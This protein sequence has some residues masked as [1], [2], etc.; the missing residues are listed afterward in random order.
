MLP[1]YKNMLASYEIAGIKVIDH[2]KDN[3]K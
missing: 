1:V 3:K 2:T